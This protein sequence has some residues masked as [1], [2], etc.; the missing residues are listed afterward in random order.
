[1]RPARH[2]EPWTESE[3]A[4]LLGEIRCAEPIAA[5]AERHERTVN[6]VALRVAALAGSVHRPGEDEDPIAWACAE[7][8]AS[9]SLPD[10]SARL[11]QSYSGKAATMRRS[12]GEF[13]VAPLDQDGNLPECRLDE[14]AARFRS[15][16]ERV[17][18]LWERIAGKGSARH[19][20]PAEIEVLAAFDDEILMD[21]GFRLMRTCGRLT[22]SDWVLECDWPEVERL[23]LTASDL[24]N[25]KEE[26][27]IASVEILSAATRKIHTERDHDVLMRRVGLRGASTKLVDIGEDYGI[28]RER[29]RQL[30]SRALVKLDVGPPG[31]VFRAWDHTRYVLRSALQ[32]PLGALDPELVLA[33]VELALPM[34]D[35]RSAVTFVARLAGHRHDADLVGERV[36]KLA[37]ERERQ[38]REQH[39]KDLTANRARK[40]FNQLV[41]QIDWPEIPA[42]TDPVACRPRRIPKVSDRKSISGRWDSPM[43]G[44]PVGYDSYAELD[45]I[46][47]MEAADMVETYCEQPVEID[48]TLYGTNR[49]YYPDFI[50]TLR[51]GRRF[52]VEIKGSVDEFAK[53]D[54][55]AKL[56]AARTFCNARG[57][58]LLAT[59]GR[60]TP[61]ILLSRIVA[62]DIESLLRE[63]LGSGVVRWPSFRELM[64]D[65]GFVWIDV[66]ALIYRRRWCW[67]TEPFRLS[68]DPT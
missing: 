38:R 7:L 12:T 13:E 50:V 5:V 6:A 64:Q 26:G 55:L 61:R 63:W 32:T 3:D 44:R 10:W 35:Q 29:V 49:K 53:Y 2:G 67:R 22:A 51:D 16:T 68:L 17:V 24:R 62:V 40:R 54:N 15:S 60:N 8:Q 56:D 27:R 21:A 34:A 46:Q 57:W 59:D 41:E 48:Y 18:G 47:R 45:F 4:Q 36:A 1:M 39:R 66:A 30:V 43:L 14:R 28:T 37:D 23:Q 19:G 58:G 65:H 42:P 20:T 31:N 9:D 25:G 11:R 33:L 52:I